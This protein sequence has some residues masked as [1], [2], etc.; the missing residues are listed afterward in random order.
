[1]QPED[2]PLREECL[3][4]MN[5]SKYNRDFSFIL[6]GLRNMKTTQGQM[7]LAIVP[8]A[9][10]NSGICEFYATMD[11]NCFHSKIM[12]VTDSNKIGG[13]GLDRL[14]LEKL[15]E[16]Y[17]DYRKMNLFD[18]LN[19]RRSPL[20]SKTRQRRSNRYMSESPYNRYA[21]V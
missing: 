12:Y 21:R 16:S 18:N 3:E 9:V 17:Y 7:C 20:L 10:F 1:M 15:P 2:I 8:T 4:R 5:L 19:S 14:F 13:Y 11:P 6:R